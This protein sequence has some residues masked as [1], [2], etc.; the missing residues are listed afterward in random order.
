MHNGGLTIIVASGAGGVARKYSVSKK[1]V[2]VVAST[3]G[4]IAACFMLSCL[5]YFHMWNKSRGQQALVAELD[6]LR[7]ENEFFRVDARQLTDQMALLETTAKKLEIMAGL[8][9]DGTAGV[10]GP[11]RNTRPIPDLASAPSL[12]K[13]FK[14]L[15]RKKINLQTEFAKLQEHYT[16]RQILL[17]ATPT[18]MPALGYLSDGYGYRRDPFSGERDWH[19]GVDISAPKGARVVATADGTV[20]RAG[21]TQGY[22]KLVDL[23]HRFGILTRYGHL[24]K[25]TVKAGQKVKRGDVIGYVGSTGRATGT[26]VHFEVRLNGEALDPMRFLRD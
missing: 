16:S 26:H 4:L 18:I 2:A 21:W 7:K 11:A 1:L 25:I 20:S 5:H 17:S 8:V 12:K 19:P 15:D 22:G 3:L 9:Q 6:Q 14:S 10:G 23:G 13:H 24:S